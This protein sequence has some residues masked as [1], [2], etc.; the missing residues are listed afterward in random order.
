[1]TE[2]QYRKAQ[3]DLDMPVFPDLYIEY[4]I[5]RTIEHYVEKAR[6]KAPTLNISKSMFRDIAD[7]IASAFGPI[8]LQ[9]SR[10]EPMFSRRQILRLRD[11]VVEKCN[12]VS[13]G[14][15]A[16]DTIPADD[17]IFISEWNPPPRH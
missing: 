17:V 12:E 9:I 13:Y 11:V 5:G 1:M 3:E 15:R 4:V 10:R 16:V 6:A 14:I 2:L 7:E 8:D